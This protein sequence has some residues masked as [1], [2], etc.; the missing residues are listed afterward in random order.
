MQRALR[1]LFRG[2]EPVDDVEVEV[3]SAGAPADN[4]GQ[5][6]DERCERQDKVRSAIA[7]HGLKI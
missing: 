7:R 4:E 6:G 2:L 5:D 1:K 3:V